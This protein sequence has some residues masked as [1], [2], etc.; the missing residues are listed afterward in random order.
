MPSTARPSEGD[1]VLRVNVAEAEDM[2]KGRGIHQV[3][4]DRIAEVESIL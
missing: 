1:Y 3:I 4:K 2:D